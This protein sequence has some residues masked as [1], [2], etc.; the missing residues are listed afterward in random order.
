MMRIVALNEVQN[1]AD[2]DENEDG[3]QVTKEA[4]VGIDGGKLGT[5]S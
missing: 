3:I 2:T 4:E 5:L 1:E